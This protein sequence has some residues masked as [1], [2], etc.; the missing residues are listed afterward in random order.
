MALNMSWE[1]EAASFLELV[2]VPCA[3]RNDRL[4]FSNYVIYQ[5]RKMDTSNGLSQIKH[6]F[7]SLV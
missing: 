4:A 3:E 1:V 2:Q 5:L 6:A 7:I